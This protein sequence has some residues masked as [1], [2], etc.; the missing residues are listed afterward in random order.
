MI[1]PEMSLAFSVYSNKGVYALLVGSGVS[2]AAGVPT[3]W[4]VVLDLIRK[5]A[6][7][8]NEDPEPEPEVWYQEKFGKLPDY[9]ELL[10]NLT[11]S[12]AERG[13]LLR[14]YFEPSEEE[15]AQGL[16]TP[17]AA[18]RAIA[19][20]IRAGFL[21]VVVT[22]NFD[23]LLE[24]ALTD[25]GIGP[26]VV[27]T[28]EAAVGCVPLTHSRCT[29]LKVHGDYLD[30]ELK[31]TRA[32]L[33]TYAYSVNRLLDQILDEFGLIV[34]GWSG[35][36]D[37]AL[38]AALERC[39]SRRYGA[40]WCVFGDKPSDVAQ[41]LID[42]RR[43]TPMKIASADEFFKSLEDKVRALE[44]FGEAEHPLSAKL[45]VARLKRHL[46]AGN[47]I[48]L[49]DLLAAETE[50]SFR[51][52]ADVEHVN[53]PMLHKPEGLAR[54]L[55]YYE[56]HSSTLLALCIAGS[57]WAK[58]E[59]DKLIVQ[60]VR[61]IAQPDAPYPD[62]S[63]ARSLRWYP[64]LLL[65]Y[66][67]G[68]ATLSSG[69]YRLLGKLL[70]MKIRPQGGSD[71]EAV[72]AA[73]NTRYVMGG[74]AAGFIPWRSGPTP[75]SDHLEEVLRE[76]LREFLPD[77]ED[78]TQTFDW[79][80]YL[81]A[82]V[83]LDLSCPAD[84]IRAIREQWEQLEEKVPVGRF[85]WRQGRGGRGLRAE[86]AVE[87]GRILPEKVSKVLSAGLFGANRPTYYERFREVQE[88]YD[89]FLG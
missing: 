69:D 64:A 19:E 58:P 16:K 4:E 72:V 43:A 68:L 28:P 80:E 13:Q 17:T 11:K 89:G 1:A 59:T 61:R 14:S 35:E 41:R 71:S 74:S 26:S 50:R 32:E 37:H 2:R 44:S 76:P 31:N 22:T 27:S 49:H 20:M 84:K 54:R 82:L 79:H 87:K 29:I 42:H 46:S 81:L 75:L 70:P 47:R 40:F 34:C 65:L 67:I 60:C 45:A 23:R 78:Y 86:T 77:E 56:H 85:K 39:Q 12:S 18:H 3:G 83:Y 8:M 25:L 10:D 48:G 73:I 57:Y 7:L 88:A 62:A 6:H 30:P 53:S 5:L 15:L 24:Q 63:F 52:L 9:S 36:W 38:R 33:E 51:A 21:R 66:G 55:S